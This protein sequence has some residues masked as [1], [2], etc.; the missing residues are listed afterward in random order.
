[1]HTVDRHQRNDEAQHG[2]VDLGFQ[3]HLQR[4][5][6]VIQ[7]RLKEWEPARITPPPTLL[8][9]NA[10]S[11]LFQANLMPENTDKRDE[12]ELELQNT[13]REVKELGDR[14]SLLNQR[15]TSD[16]I[17]VEFREGADKP[18]KPPPLSGVIK[19]EL[20]LM[21]F[22]VLFVGIISTETYYYSFGIKYQFLSLPASHVIYRGLTAIITSPSLLIPYIVAVAWLVLD[23]YAPRLNLRWLLPLQ[24]PLSYILMLVLLIIAYPLARRTGRLEASSDLR[25]NTSSL[26]TL[27]YLKTSDGTEYKSDK[28]Y[29][30]LMIDSDYVIFFKPLEAAEIASLPV[31]HRVPRGEVHVLDAAKK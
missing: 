11:L 29:R 16:T 18:A 24:R 17:K 6:I 1:M 28:G 4:P 10:N 27:I 15:L 19:D 3:R 21:S 14:I 23:G 8:T 20:V 2:S 30:L 13:R 12:M 25:I 22:L 26:P 7:V 31:I 5:Q 9:R